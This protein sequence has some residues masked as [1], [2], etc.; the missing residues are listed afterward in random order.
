MFYIRNRYSSDKSPPPLDLLGG[1]EANSH[2]PE[3]DPGDPGPV[4]HPLAIPPSAFDTPHVH[5][6]KA[7]VE[8]LAELSSALFPQNSQVG[9]DPGPASPDSAGA[10]SSPSIFTL[11]S[12]SP[13]GSTFSWPG[14][15]CTSPE[16]LLPS[17]TSSAFSWASPVS[18][19]SSRSAYSPEEYGSQHSQALSSPI[20]PSGHSYQEG[21]GPYPAGAPFFAPGYGIHPSAFS[22]PPPAM[23]PDPTGLCAAS[24]FAASPPAYPEYYELR[25]DALLPHRPLHVDDPP[26]QATPLIQ[27]ICPLCGKELKH[28]KNLKP[29]LREKHDPNCFRHHCPYPSCTASYLRASDLRN[30][31][32][33]K[34]PTP[35]NPSL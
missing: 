20:P 21:Y 22:L 16:G 25:A 6:L 8:A 5:A 35:P 11:T 29:H 28:K 33:R 7:Q 34:H 32:A 12:E 9:F 10:A 3:F 24:P 31:T 23:P 17:P 19:F 15:S 13:P 27:A 1:L 30:H 4:P 18:P 26:Q 2:G 14:T